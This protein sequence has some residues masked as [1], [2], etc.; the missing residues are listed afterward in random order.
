ML[1][2]VSI[3]KACMMVALFCPGPSRAHHMNGSGAGRQ[4]S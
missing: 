3:E 1:L 2:S 4:A